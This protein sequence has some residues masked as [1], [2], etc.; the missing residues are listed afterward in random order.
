MP[1]SSESG[2]NYIR[3]LVSTIKHDKILDIGCGSGTY[4]KM[5]PDSDLTGIEVWGPYISQ[6]GLS[7][8]YDKL[9]V[10]DAREWIP[11]DQYDLAIAGD[12]LEHMTVD[13]A[14]ELLNKL[15]QCAKNVLISIPIGHYPQDEYEGN[16]YERH[17]KDDWSDDEVRQY[18]GKPT[19]SMIDNE[20]GVYM[21][22]SEKKKLKIAV[23]GISKN[24]EKFAERF[25]K[26]AKIGRAHV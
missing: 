22:S 6:Y 10:E 25:C 4:A 13:E 16:P 20:I 23:Y 21:Y 7:D 5:F 11:D 19:Y 17:I 24:E 9:I 2:K 1:F 3:N 8:L 12:V 26:A 18:F 14:V 15:K